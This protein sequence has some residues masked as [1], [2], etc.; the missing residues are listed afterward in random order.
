MSAK[1]LTDLMLE[2]NRLMAENERLRAQVES[3]SEQLTMESISVSQAEIER[4]RDRLSDYDEAHRMT[5][6]DCGSPDEA[7]CSCVPALRMEI[8]RL[9]ARVAELEK[10][11]ARYQWLRQERYMFREGAVVTCDEQAETVALWVKCPNANDAHEVDVAI[12]ASIVD[13]RNALKPAQSSQPVR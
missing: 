12:D 2:N 1:R 3:L 6:D 13:A 9:Q 11:A 7:H 5:V 10:D 4:L 8:E